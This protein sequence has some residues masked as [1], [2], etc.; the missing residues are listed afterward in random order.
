VLQIEYFRYQFFGDE[1]VGCR[2]F[3]LLDAHFDKKSVRF[4]TFVK[5]VP[6]DQKFDVAVEIKYL[7]PPSPPTS[8]SPIMDEQLEFYKKQEF[9]AV[10]E[11]RLPCGAIL[12]RYSKR[13]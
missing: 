4:E 12:A 9:G 8:P 10:K 2:H 3:P 7:P 5:D 1:K 13:N 6:N 11:V